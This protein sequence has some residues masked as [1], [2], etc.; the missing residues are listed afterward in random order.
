MPI[1]SAKGNTV[2]YGRIYNPQN[3][4]L[5]D[6]VMVAV[7]RAPKSFTGEDTAEISA[8][9]N[10]FILKEI[11]GTLI[12]AGARIAKPGEFTQRAFLNGKI[13]LPRAE[14]INDIIRA[15]TSYARA[16]ALSRLEGVLSGALEDIHS[17]ILDLIARIEVAIDHSDTDNE[18][19]GYEDFLFRLNGIIAKIDKLLSTAQAGK[20][21]SSGL[22]LAIIG[23]PNT[24][25]SSLMNTLLQEDRVIVSDME[26]TTRDTVENELNIQGI[27][28][29]LIDTAGVRIT[30][31]PV[32]NLGIKRTIDTIKSADLRI[33]LLD[34]TRPFQDRDRQV[35]DTVA[36]LD[37]IIAVNKCDISQ[38][39]DNIKDLTKRFPEAIKISAMTGEGIGL[40]EKATYDFYFSFGVNPESDALIANI[41]Q[42]NLLETT[43]VSLEKAIDTI[44]QKMSEEFIAYEVRKA[45]NSIEEILGKTTDDAVLDRIFSNFCIGK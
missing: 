13:D 15:H 18:F 32:E 21:L 37:N 17:S 43:K 23:A 6:E 26:G 30:D 42:Q 39:K 22:R 14:A 12:A 7:F 25:K 33:V 35:L 20:I 4:A 2:I 31:D 27:P 40:I 44:S 36:G 29:R 10:P 45:R 19:E 16:S 41:R 8:H 38:T 34:A 1:N 3:G 28:V 5:I 9:G 24:G 11:T